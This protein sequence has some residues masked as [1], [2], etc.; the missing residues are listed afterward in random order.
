MEGAAP[1]LTVAGL[2]GAV[3]SVGKALEVGIKFITEDPEAAKDGAK[4]V[5]GEMV[6]LGI[7]QLIP[8]PN[9]SATP[10]VKELAKIGKETTKTIASD[11]AVSTI[12]E[13][14]K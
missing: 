14:R 13:L 10:F 11:K 5:V 9:P 12:N 6:G 3:S 2:G 1:G 8:G 4:Y 7:N